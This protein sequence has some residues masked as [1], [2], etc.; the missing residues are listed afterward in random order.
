MNNIDPANYKLG[1]EINL[2]G[3]NGVKIKAKIISNTEVVSKFIKEDD[4]KCVLKT[5]SEEGDA[6]AIE[7]IDQSFWTI[8]VDGEPAKPGTSPQG[9]MAATLNDRTIRFVTK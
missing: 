4:G 2:G 3:E 9:K 1:Q 8:L 5:R 6:V 7:E